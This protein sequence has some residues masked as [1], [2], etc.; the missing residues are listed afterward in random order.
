VHTAAASRQTAQNN[1]SIRGSGAN[2]RDGEA[3]SIGG[4]VGGLG[5]GRTSAA[6]GALKDGEGDGG[7]RGGGSGGGIDTDGREEGGD[8]EC[9]VHVGGWVGELE[10]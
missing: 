8:G 6:A 9:G 1:T 2:E 5:R 7:D 3:R 4:D 10:A